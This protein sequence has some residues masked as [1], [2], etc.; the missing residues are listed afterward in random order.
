MKVY[1]FQ[2]TLTE[3]EL[4]AAH[5]L[6]VVQ[7][8]TNMVYALNTSTNQMQPIVVEGDGTVVSADGAEQIV[9]TSV[10]KA[11]DNTEVQNS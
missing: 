4:E 1:L 9:V 7:D 11:I 2:A 5:V 3:K 8:G 6:T 10:A